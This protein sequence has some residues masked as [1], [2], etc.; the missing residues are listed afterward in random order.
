MNPIFVRKR[1]MGVFHILGVAVG[2]FRDVAGVR[3]M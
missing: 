3:M 2:L 1:E